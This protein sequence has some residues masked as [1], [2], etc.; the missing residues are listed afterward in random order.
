[1]QRI[2]YMIQCAYNDNADHLTCQPTDNKSIAN[3]YNLC[4]IAMKPFLVD[5][6]HWI[7]MKKQRRSRKIIK[8]K[9][10]KVMRGAGRVGETVQYVYS[11]L[12]L[13][14]D[15]AHYSPKTSLFRKTDL[16]RFGIPPYMQRN[17]Y[18][19]N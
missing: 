10:K 3:E 1:M 2:L 4:T 13:T 7:N 17:M 19:Y 14:A 11:G 8:R 9:R 16:N 5:Y 6:P 15:V 18:H 12:K